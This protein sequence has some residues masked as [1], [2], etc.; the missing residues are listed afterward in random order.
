M[1]TA[2]QALERATEETGLDDFGAPSFRAG[3]DRL[4]EAFG[5][6][7]RLTELGQAMAERS[8]VA[9]LCNRL[10]VEAWWAEHP[11]LAEET[12]E[13]P[14]VV[15]GMS[16]S[17]TTALS[18]LLGKDPEL[19]SLRSWEAN[20]SVP[21]PEQATYWR[22][23]R[24]L[25]AVEAEALGEGPFP[26]L[27]ALHHDPPEA[28]VECNSL[29][30]HEFNSTVFPTVYFLPSFLRW[31]M[32]ADAEG[33]YAY[34]ERMLK[35]LQSRFPG[36]WN[37]KGPQHGYAMDEL[38][39][40]YPDATL[41]VT[42]RDPSACTASTA[43]LMGFFAERTSGGYD[44]LAVGDVTTEFMLRCATGLVEDHRKH[45]PDGM[46]HIAYPDLVTD[47]IGTVRR[48]Y[49]A[50]GRELTA[51]AEAAM[52]EHVATRPQHKYGVHR[53]DPADFGLQRDE[54]DRRFDEYRATFGV[55]LDRR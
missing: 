21:P 36:R 9:T 34:H 6:E 3:L 26:G 12:I 45:G 31:M 44:P 8:V 14:I 30:A 28:P 48:L 54:L 29:F 32:D 25:A 2:D 40:R 20:A 53:Y 33:I 43:S 22:D 41:I 15:V 17:G 47:P 49:E 4:L 37:L 51:P 23:P 24:Y 1:I 27:R 16:R 38:R 39:R 18:H 42:H 11:E 50:M 7:A 19:R 35:L 5:G 10:R 13:A 46:I 55:Q 52:A